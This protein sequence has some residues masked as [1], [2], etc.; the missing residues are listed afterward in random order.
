MSLPHALLTSLLEKPSSGSELTRRFEKSI[1]YFWQATHQQ[2]YRELG[3]LEVAGWV[4][5]QAEEGARG[6]KRSYRVLPA[7][8][9]E[10]WRWV[11]EQSDPR[12]FKDEIMLRLRAEAVVGPSGLIEDLKRRLQIHQ[13]RLAVYKAIEAKDFLGKE[14]TRERRL[15]HLI[16]RAGVMVESMY[17]QFSTEA[18]DILQEDPIR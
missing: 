14:P 4:E 5:S 3:R 9:E 10:L 1:G 6:R 12:P 17:I 2:I 8:K 18:L 15:K 13:Q 11:S 16:L 7:G